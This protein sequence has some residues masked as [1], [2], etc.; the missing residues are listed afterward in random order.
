MKPGWRPAHVTQNSV[1]GAAAL[2]G[3]LTGTLQCDKTLNL[4]LGK[5]TL[6]VKPDRHPA[7]VM[8]HLHF[9]VLIIKHPTCYQ[10]N[11]LEFYA[12]SYWCCHAVSA[13]CVRLI[14]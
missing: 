10:I 9:E 3:S 13:A 14:E 12:L 5:G 11:Q 7:H 2:R 4:F 6:K 8:Q 1:V